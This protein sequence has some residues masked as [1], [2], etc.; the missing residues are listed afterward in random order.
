MDLGYEAVLN[1]LTVDERGVLLDGPLQ[2]LN[3]GPYMDL[4]AGEYEVKFDLFLPERAGEDADKVC[5]LRANTY[6]GENTLEIQPVYRG[7][8][9]ADGRLTAT[10]RFSA[11][12]ARA[13]EFAVV[14]EDEPLY[15]G[16]L[17]VQK[18]GT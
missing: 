13:T 18:V 4:F 5:T 16:G 6:W 10:L 15:I 8:F 11:G 17:T 1:G 7:D 2:S 14:A 12:Y 3:Q 9:D